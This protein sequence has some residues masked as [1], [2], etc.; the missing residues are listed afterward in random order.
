MARKQRR[1]QGQPRVDNV[2]KGFQ[3]SDGP[4]TGYQDAPDGK[5]M[6]KSFADGWIPEGWHDTPAKCDNCDGKSH[7]EYVEG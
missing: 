3:A 4:T 5:V 6:R 7:P 2:A 1:E